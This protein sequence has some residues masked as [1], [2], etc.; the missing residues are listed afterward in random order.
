MGLLQ[1]Q[2]GWG[3]VFGGWAS[4]AGLILV[5]AWARRR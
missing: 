4:V 3:A 5:I 2:L 1:E